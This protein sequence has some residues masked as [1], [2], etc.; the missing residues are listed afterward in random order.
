M[1][2][3]CDGFRM[4]E[5]GQLTRASWELPAAGPGEA[6][7][8][9]AGC[10]V[11]HTD[12][13]FLY[14]GVPTRK[15]LPLVLGHEIS[16]KVIEA[17]PDC[18]QWLGRR[19]VAPAVAT[20]G[21]CP[22]CLAG[23]PT[24]CK[25][26][27]MPGNDH[28]GGFATH[29]VVPARTLCDVDF[30]R[31]V[32]DGPLGEA[33]LELWELSV[34]ADAV[35]T[36][37]QAIRRAGLIPGGLAVFVGVGGVGGFGVQLAAALGARVVA[38][39]VDE[40]KLDRARQYG[41]ALSL[42]AKQGVKPLKGALREAAR[43]LGTPADGWRIFET[44]GTAK[45]QEL[46]FALLGHAGVLSVVGFTAESVQVRLSNLMALDAT[47]YGNWGADPGLYPEAVALCL[48]GKIAVRPFVKRYP[49][50]EAPAVLEHIHHAGALE[51]AVLVP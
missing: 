47:A 24:A 26:G 20:C 36:P 12:L 31:P 21:S 50:A 42:D 34:V 48:E 35:S 28:D 19:V 13:S 7:L 17:G 25:L 39:D 49:L 38:I 45:G 8:E 9:V 14:D 4:T 40:R 27:K 23:R 3:Q 16:G 33:R 41:A 22:H 18:Q 5:K 2:T 43:S 6:I 10:G 30:G 32:G 44:S 15:P 11:C 51:R 37:L 29:V 1:A 46:A